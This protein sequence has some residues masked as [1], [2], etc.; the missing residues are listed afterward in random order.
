MNTFLQRHVLQDKVSTICWHYVL[1]Y[2][3]CV[4]RTIFAEIVL[5]RA[6][7]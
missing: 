1:H 5:R 7:F 2:L 4:A 6:F 3:L